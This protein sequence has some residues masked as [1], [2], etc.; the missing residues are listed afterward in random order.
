MV[1]DEGAGYEAEGRTTYDPFGDDVLQALL[2]TNLKIYDALMALLTVADEQ[3]A[4]D[5]DSLH[6]NGL[7]LGQG[8]TFARFVPRDDVPGDNSED[9]GDVIS[10]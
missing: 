7:V 8:P 3:V 5:L 10:G 6:T 2:I 9:D 1:N 4:E